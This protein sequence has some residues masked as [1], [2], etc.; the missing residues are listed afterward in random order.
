MTF[1]IFICKR[2]FRDLGIKSQNL[3]L[4]AV[5]PKNNHENTK[6]GKHEKGQ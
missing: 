5:A 4:A 3:K 2:E 6:Q 1:E